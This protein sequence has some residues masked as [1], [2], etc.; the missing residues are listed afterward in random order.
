MRR[1]RPRT[2]VFL[3]VAGA[4]ACLW[5]FRET[6]LLHAP[7]LIARLRDPIGPPH[8]VSW[9]EGPSAPAAAP[10][11]RPPNVVVILADD[12]GINDLTV[13][14]RGGVAGGAVATP[15]IDSLAAAGVRLTTAYTGN[16]TCA[17]SR[18]AILTGRYPTR[19]GFEFTPA[20]KAF[21]RLL[22]RVLS[23]GPRPAVYFADREAAVPPLAD[24]GLPRDE[25][26]LAE[27]LRGRGYRTLFLGKWHLG[28]SPAMRPD[29][30]GFDE[31]LGFL[32]G[33]S[34]YA[35]RGDPSV[36]E[37]RQAFD[38]IDRFLWANLPFAVSKDGGPRFSPN[39]YMTDY[40]AQE[41]S[42]AIAANRNRPFFLYLALNTPHTPLQA[43]RADYDALPGITN[44]TERVYAA[45]V[46]SLDRAVGEVLDALRE[47]GLEDNTLVLFTSDNGGAHYVGLPGHQPAVPR[48]EG[49]VLRGRHPHAVLGAVARRLARRDHVRRAGRARRRVRHGRGRRRGVAP[50]RPSA[51]RRRPPAVPARGGAR[52]AARDALLALG[53]LSR[54]ASG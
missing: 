44:H 39:A 20:P 5:A 35:E 16:A 10:S 25:I 51:R 9:A 4:L 2:M 28:E 22:A 29:A 11:A 1:L 18:A 48:L 36:V 49:D 13:A 40:L 31:W 41:A 34:L 47:N 42:R 19:F 12:L 30:Q 37:S 23:G 7:G 17:P 6:I 8:A 43:L 27:L 14:G 45:M 38:P 26:T 54:A 3:A 50:G 52:S 46:R 33:A 24:Q 15:H 53:A 32:A 21:S